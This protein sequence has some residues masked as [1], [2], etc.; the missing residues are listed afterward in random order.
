MLVTVNMYIL[1]LGAI[2]QLPMWVLG[3]E[4]LNGQVQKVFMYYTPTVKIELNCQSVNSLSW[5]ESLFV[6]KP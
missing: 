3:F 6:S 5:Q 2:K 1:I 4:D